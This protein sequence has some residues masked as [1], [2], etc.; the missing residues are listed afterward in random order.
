[1]GVSEI[2]FV[3]HTT[4]FDESVDFYCESLGLEL[5]EE[6][7]EGGHGAVIRLTRGADLELIEL[8][9]AD[10]H[11]GVALGLE[12]DDVDACYLRLQTAGVTT[13]A[14]PLDAFGK[15]G[16]G[17]TDPNGVA[18]NIYTSERNG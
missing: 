5:V 12:V 11:A 8:E 3:I 14:P 6:W 18:V 9:G 16:F 10:D 15:R 1:M 2:A 17:T 13:K 4:R 7:R